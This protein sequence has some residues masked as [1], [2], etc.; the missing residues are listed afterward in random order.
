[1]TKDREGDLTQAAFLLPGE[2]LGIKFSQD[3]LNISDYYTI[4]KVSHFI[5][6]DNWLTT[7]DLWKE[8]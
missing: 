5:D 4:T 7:I 1:M 6:P 8:A 2:L 3:V